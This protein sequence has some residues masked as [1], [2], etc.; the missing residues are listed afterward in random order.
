MDYF[1]KDSGEVMEE[2]VVKKI[3]N[4]SSNDT[5]V[6]EKN[7]EKQIDETENEKIVKFLALNRQ[8]K[9]N[10]KDSNRSSNFGAPGSQKLR[11]SS[12]IEVIVNLNCIKSIYFLKVI[13]NFLMQ[14]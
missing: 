5:Q 3:L 1:F 10:F 14:S 6:A 2:N 9:P 7:I 12:L 11:M 8:N 4:L 13:H